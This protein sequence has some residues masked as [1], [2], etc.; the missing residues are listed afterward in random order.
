LLVAG[1]IQLCIQSKFPT[2][3]SGDK[4]GWRR[5]TSPS[6]INFVKHDEFFALQKPKIKCNCYS[7]GASKRFYHVC[8]GRNIAFQW[9]RY[10]HTFFSKLEIGVRMCKTSAA[11]EN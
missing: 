9:Q 2:Y 4:V 1:Q 11:N 7:F 3:N 10:L 6:G 8:Q 5:P